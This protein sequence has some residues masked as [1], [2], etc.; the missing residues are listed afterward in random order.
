[1]KKFSKEE[2]IKK[3]KKIHNNKYDY[4]KTYYNNSRSNIIVICPIHGEFEQ[5]ANSHLSGNG[6][7]KCASEKQ[8]ITKEEFIKKAKKIHNNKY[9]YSK[10]N[11]VN[12][13]E[14]VVIICPIHGEFKQRPDM[15][16]YQGTMCPLCS[17]E[18]R[19]KIRSS[20]TKEFVERAKTIHKDRY[21]YTKVNYVNSKKKVKIICL[22]HGEFE[23]RPNDHLSGKGCPICSRSK[24]EILIENWL[25][26]NNIA[27]EREKKFKKCKYKKCLPFDFYL[28]EY[29]ILIEYDGEQHFKAT[30]GYFTEELLS[31]I[32]KKDEIKNEFCKKN[33]INLMR[34]SYKDNVEK[35]LQI[36]KEFQKQW[37][38]CFL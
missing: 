1:M 33:N 12:N 8:K 6:C 27:F 19:K 10:V 38:C 30:G 3:A 20:N 14:N 25:S 15:H 22:I 9:D 4:S 7:K 34:I 16:L 2:F 26:E 21:D 17:I 24:G 36:L 32:K 11:Y 28:P 31:S 37:L 23:Q 5:R 29:N 18:K 35:K 13:K